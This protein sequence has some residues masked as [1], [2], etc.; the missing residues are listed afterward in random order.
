MSN[1]IGTAYI[2]IAP[3]MSGVQSKI[4]GGL[5]GSGSAFAEQFGGEVSG[6]SAFIIGAIAGVA[7]AGVTKAMNL[8]TQSIGSA[9]KRVDTLNAAQKTF[10]YMGFAADDAAAATKAVTKSIL[11]LPTPLDSAVRGMTSLAATYQDVK[12]G[13]K[14]F[15]ALND[16]I[17]GFGGSAEMVDNA[18]QQ[19]SQLPLDGPLDA[20]TWNSLRNSGLTPV[21]V[22]MG[23]DM[24]KSVSQ[25]KQDFGDGTLKVQ[26]FVNAL[27]KMDTQGGGGL[28]SLQQIAKNATSGI[29]TGFDNMQTAVSRGLAAI[30]QA[31]G[32]KNISGAISSIGSAFERVLK[33]IVPLIGF[34]ARNKDIFAPIAV[35]IGAVVAAMTAWATVTKIMTIAQTVFNAVMAANPIGL[36]ILAIAGLVAG[37]TYFFTQTETGKK[38]FQSFG[39]ILGSVF[40]AIITAVT[41]VGSFFASVFSSIQAVVSG[42]IDWIKNNWTLILAI[43]IGPVGLAVLYITRHWQSIKDGAANMLNS[44]VGFFQALPSRILG[45]IGNL[46]RLL[47]D[48]GRDMINGLL[49]GAGSLLSRI[50]QF[51]LDK[52]PGWIQGP[53]KK[54][55]G[56]HSPSTVFAGYGKNITQGLVNGISK[57]SG[58]IADAVNTMADRAMSAMAGTTVDANLNANVGANGAYGGAIGSAAAAGGPAIIQNNSIYNQ[59]DINTVTRELAWQVRR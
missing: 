17:L 56:I 9:I 47:Y 6:K 13:Q 45:A 2:N 19:I 1:T 4:A 38:I 7:Q 51:F 24:G 42:T 48:S 55:L 34:I 40:S 57:N 52:L 39:Q 15:S 12:L 49:N 23:K 43:L 5:R 20:Q 59:V 28:V 53:F 37:L 33:G 11:G 30:I 54:A 3:N 35:G 26:D 32:Q 8:V 25:L 44:L 50:G 22:A 21:L 10:Q 41:A 29:G 46:G 18:I 58:S 36:I 27:V 14:V 31:I 16:A